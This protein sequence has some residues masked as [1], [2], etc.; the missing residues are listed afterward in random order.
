[1]GNRIV[2]GALVGLFAGSLVALSGVL[3]LEEAIE[4]VDDPIDQVK[5]WARYAVWVPPGAAAFIASCTVVAAVWAAANAI[6]DDVGEALNEV[7]ASY[8]IRER[9]EGSD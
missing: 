4:A 3:L 5:W 6:R 1:M 9:D 2:A 8:D 7:L